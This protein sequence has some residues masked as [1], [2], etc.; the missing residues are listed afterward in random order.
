M[1]GSL[2]RDFSFV[3]Q[4]LLLCF[5]PPSLVSSSESPNRSHSRGRPARASHPALRRAPDGGCHRWS[6]QHCSSL[7]PFL[8]PDGRRRWGNAPS[9]LCRG[10]V[11]GKCVEDTSSVCKCVRDVMRGIVLCR[12]IFGR[13]MRDRDLR[14]ATIRSVCPEQVMLS[15]SDVEG[16]KVVLYVS[17]LGPCR[18]CR[19][20]L[21]NSNSLVALC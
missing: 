5:P 6:G 9:T 11:K 10:V 4:A 21:Q 20:D 18:A 8:V 12:M 19:S 17:R 15:G 13:A 1:V 2:Q 14:G 16:V 7:R 3:L